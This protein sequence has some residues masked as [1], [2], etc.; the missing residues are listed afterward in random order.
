MSSPLLF[1]NMVSVCSEITANLF[2]DKFCLNF[3][4]T[5]RPHPNIS[6]SLKIEE[7]MSRTLSDTKRALSTPVIFHISWNSYYLYKIYELN[8]KTDEKFNFE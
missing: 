5:H 7:D 8:N 1:W 4:S 6:E 3:Y 2:A